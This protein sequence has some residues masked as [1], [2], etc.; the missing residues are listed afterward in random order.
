LPS[1]FVQGGT[2][3]PSG[4]KTEDYFKVN[5]FTV[6]MKNPLSYS[7]QEAFR[8]RL[9]R[10]GAAYAMSLL[11]FFPLTRRKAFLKLEFLLEL[12]L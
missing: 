2:L 8:A 10:D 6:F 3:F 4:T 5:S 11:Q 12:L 9:T 1:P 7:P